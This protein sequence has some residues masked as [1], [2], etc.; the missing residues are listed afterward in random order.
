MRKTINFILNLLFLLLLLLLIIYSMDY[1]YELHQLKIITYYI[2]LIVKNPFLPLAVLSILWLF[3]R[4]ILDTWNDRKHHSILLSIYYSI[5]AI[6][7]INFLTYVITNITNNKSLLLY[8][9]I[10]LI[11]FVRLFISVIIISV[12][13]CNINKK[14]DAQINKLIYT[15][16]KF[17]IILILLLIITTIVFSILMYS[18]IY[19]HYNFFINNINEKLGLYSGESR[20]TD[21]LDFI[22][23]STTT[24]FTIG[25]GDI[26]PKGEHLKLIVQSEMFLGYFMTILFIPLIFNFINDLFSSSIKPSQN[27]TSSLIPIIDI[28][29]SVQLPVLKLEEAIKVL[30]VDYIYEVDTS[31]FQLIDI[32]LL[33]YRTSFK[34]MCNNK[35]YFFILIKENKYTSLDIYENDFLLIKKDS[36]INFKCLIICAIKKNTILDCIYY[37]K[38]FI[39]LDKKEIIVASIYGKISEID[40]EKVKENIYKIKDYTNRCEYTLNKTNFI[41]IGKIESKKSYSR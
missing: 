27:H 33:G 25:Y 19:Y 26:V 3:S 2:K 14:E 9:I 24:F 13:I 20:I 11:S 10:L 39:D 18:K 23:F 32:N 16:Y 38:N 29:N 5:I 7:F 40:G 30:P 6:I 37:D 35:D 12:K 41:I 1:M 31:L 17:R 22:Y 36:S 34:F 4:D 15:I 21:K 28:G 8:L